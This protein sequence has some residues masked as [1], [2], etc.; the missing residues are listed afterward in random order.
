MKIIARRNALFMVLAVHV[1][2]D[3]LLAWNGTIGESPPTIPNLAI[4]YAMIVWPMSQACLIAIWA[5]N[6]RM[7]FSLR[8]VLAL[9]G[10]AA[11]WIVLFRL[12]GP[13]AFDGPEFAFMLITQLVAI[14]LIINAGRLVR[15]QFRIWRSGWTE[16]DARRTQFSLRQMLM[17]TAI[18]AIIL[19]TGKALFARLGWTVDMLIDEAFYTLQ[20]FA[21]FNV[22]YAL[23]VFGL[24]TI[25]V[26]WPVRITLF[27]LVVAGCGALGWL[28][29]LIME[30]ITR[31]AP[32]ETLSMAML[33][34]APQVIYHTITLWPLWMCGCIGRRDDTAAD[35]HETMPAPGNPFAQ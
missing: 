33:V 28:M 32:L 8:L 30:L 6:S 14:L 27:L 9:A 2:I 4:V 18:L 23:L 25:R 17:W 16:A 1:A 26:W 10:T 7:R 5:A 12:L 21:A 19:G 20:L 15:R 35:P 3:L 31:P 13:S 11:A 22:L 24:F 34:A 29:V